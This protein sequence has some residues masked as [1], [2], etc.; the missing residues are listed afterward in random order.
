MQPPT[1]LVTYRNVE[2]TMYAFNVAGTELTMQVRDRSIGMPASVLEFSL[3]DARCKQIPDLVLD[4]VSIKILAP[5][6]QSQG[7]PWRFEWQR[8]R[9]ASKVERKTDPRQLELFRKP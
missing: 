4:D 3:W 5:W 6:L 9:A 7:R 1:V 2:W 8:K